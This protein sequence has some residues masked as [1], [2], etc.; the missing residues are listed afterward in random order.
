MA[1][2]MGDG[3][4]QAEAFVIASQGGVWEELLQ[5]VRCCY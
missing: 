1:A 4:A 3:R 2:V 5:V